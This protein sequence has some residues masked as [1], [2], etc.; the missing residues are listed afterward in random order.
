MKS[1]LSLSFQ[2]RIMMLAAAFALSGCE[3][4]PQ[5]DE[6]AHGKAGHGDD[7][8]HWDYYGETGPENWG[9]LHPDF[10]V[11]KDGKRQS[12]I[13]LTSAN[14]AGKFPL[15]LSYNETDLN[16]INNGH[17]I[18]MNQDAGSEVRYEGKSYQLKQFHFHSPSEHTINGKY[19]DLEC[20]FV[21]ATAEGELLVIGVFFEKSL[22]T[23]AFLA[24]FW[25][26]LPGKSGQAKQDA[27][28]KINVNAAF[29]ESGG[30]FH[31]DGS[32]TTPPGTE[33]VK[34]FVFEQAQPMSLD[35]WNAFRSIF[36]GN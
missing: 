21:H 33:G 27:D 26:D 29:P 11:M 23:D 8:K 6:A 31:Y 5:G 16:L 20:H 19:F 24:S 12:P 17:T 14:P 3:L 10:A 4:W 35:Q 2:A 32:L 36:E 28:T 15:K 7:H 9:H 22:Q 25:D 30:V 1:I 18:K 13:D 34:W